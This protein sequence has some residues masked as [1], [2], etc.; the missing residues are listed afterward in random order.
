[1][2]T[3]NHVYRIFTGCSNEFAS[4]KQLFD[5]AFVISGMIKVEISVISRDVH[6]PRPWSFRISQKLNLIIVLLHIVLKKTTTINRLM[7]PERILL[8]ESCIGGATYRLVSYLL[9]DN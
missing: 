1:M 6:V 8:L 9:A 3:S 2:Q 5:E 4:N 7:E